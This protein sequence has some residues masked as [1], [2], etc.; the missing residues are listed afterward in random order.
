M[1]RIP[2]SKAIGAGA[3]LLLLVWGAWAVYRS[4]PPP[5]ELT[6]GVPVTGPEGSSLSATT[7][8]AAVFQ[9]AFWRRP[10]PDDKILHA[11]RREWTAPADGVRKWQW[12]IAFHPGPQTREWIASNPFGLVPALSG[13][14]AS[15]E[16]RPA[17]FPEPATDFRIQQDREGHLIWIQATEGSVLYATDSGFGFAVPAAK[18]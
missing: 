9:K 12:F 4:A 1:D 8:P 2:V 3:L 5:A 16:N 18:P 14:L 17:W 6:R 7:D 10:A 11:E 15:L 13:S